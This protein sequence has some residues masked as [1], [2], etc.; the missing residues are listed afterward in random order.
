MSPDPALNDDAQA[1]DGANE[2]APV[3]AASAPV[4]AA[5]APVLAAPAPA[6]AAPA[7]ARPV[8]AS[9]PFSIPSL[10]G[11]RAVSFLIVFVAHAGLDGIV[12]G[13]FGV[14]VFF[15]LSGFLITTL[16]RVE[17]RKTGAVS[18]PG[19]Y[20]R[21][22]FR[23]LPPFYLTLLAATALALVGFTP[24]RPEG[25]PMRALLF[26]YGNY[27]FT[28]HGSLGVPAGTPVYWSLAVEEHFYLLFP[29]V[30]LATRRLGL[31]G[32]RQ[33]LLFLG[34]CALIMCWR[35]LLVLALNAPT[36][37]TYLASDT[38][39]DSILFGCALAVVAN[40]AI[41][42]PRG[43]ERLWKRILLPGGVA[44][45]LFTFLYRAPWFRES[46]RYTLQ[47]IGLM[48]IFI[49][50]I[51]F[52]QFGPFRLLN[53]RGIAF[54]GVLSY[55]LYLG[56]HVALYTTRFQLPHLHPVLQGLVALAAS[57]VFALAMYRWVERPF[58]RLRR[59]FSVA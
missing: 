31:D 37:R 10:D 23:I 20:L 50:A 48:P 24:G 53:Q 3:L 33:G 40:P 59:R 26:H 5:S 8:A 21:R 51:R 13:G 44:L 58:A 47:G 43:S 45:L 28:Y 17:E 9:K 15:F 7:P 57:L 36:D 55:S 30:Y 22:V 39:F 46:M 41:D 11:L 56:H 32:R 12:P 38:R 35:L 6:L 29:C 54:L 14:T 42:P 25:A 27:W 4:L 34:V 49:S 16:M 18:I 52:P 19:F 2:P 1:A